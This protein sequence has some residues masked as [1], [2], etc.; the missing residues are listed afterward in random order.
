VATTDP[1]SGALRKLAEQEGYATFDIPK[2]VGGRFSVL[3]AVGLFPIAVAGADI[4]KMLFGA[5][6]AMTFCKGTNAD[7]QHRGPLC[8]PPQ[9]P[10]PARFTTEVL[11]SFQPQFHF[12]GEWWKQLAGESEGKMQHRHIPGLARLHHRP[13]FDGTVDA[14][15]RAVGV[16][17][18]PR[19]RRDL[20]VP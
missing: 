13:S 12:L 20:A 7:E 8:D 18:L 9:H 1:K 11:A 19:A 17:D 16:R 6:Q 2:D 4:G 14:G 15:G 10:F 5:A 3:T